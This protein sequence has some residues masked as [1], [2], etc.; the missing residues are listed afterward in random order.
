MRRAKRRYSTLDHIPCLLV[1]LNVFDILREIIQ[2]AK[3]T[4]WIPK[5]RYGGVPQ[6][7]RDPKPGLL[8]SLN[9]HPIFNFLYIDGKG[10]LPAR[11]RA[12][13]RRNLHSHF[14]LIAYDLRMQVAT[15]E[16]YHKCMSHIVWYYISVKNSPVHVFDYN[17]L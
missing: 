15:I 1:E 2:P 17:P 11:H 7:R 12:H 4:E 5:R 14:V 13:A 16:L 6:A 8:T 9:H 10:G 3:Q